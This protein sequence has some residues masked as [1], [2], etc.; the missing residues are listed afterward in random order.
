MVASAAAKS[1]RTK[2]RSS[3]TKR[4][5][6]SASP[7]AAPAVGASLLAFVVVYFVVF[8]AGVYYILKLMSHSPHRG[9]EGPERGHP[10]RAAGITP[11]SAVGE[12]VAHGKEA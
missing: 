7:L 5:A 11:A 2:S 3:S 10:V 9:E 8:G 6:T 1:V 12:S 4:R